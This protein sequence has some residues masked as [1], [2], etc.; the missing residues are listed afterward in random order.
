MRKL[1]RRRGMWRSVTLVVHRN[2]SW[3]RSN[4]VTGLWC[5]AIADRRFIQALDPG[6]SYGTCDFFAWHW[7]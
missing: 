7:K 2:G 6:L 3:E 1:G 5:S 4:C